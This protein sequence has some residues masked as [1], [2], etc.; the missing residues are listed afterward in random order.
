M[1]ATA[2]VKNFEEFIRFIFDFISWFLIDAVLHR[3]RDRH[4]R[5]RRRRDRHRHHRG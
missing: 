3:R 2:I 5:D 1:I 4:R